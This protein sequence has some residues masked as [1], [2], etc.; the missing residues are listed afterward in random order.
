MEGSHFA[1]LAEP[2]LKLKS[3]LFP[4]TMLATIVAIGFLGSPSSGQVSEETEHFVKEARHLSQDNDLSLLNP[5]KSQEL[6]Q[7][8]TTSTGLAISPL[9]V[10]GCLGFYHWWVAAPEKRQHLN[11]FYQPYIWGTF[12]AISLLFLLNSCIGTIIP[13]LKKPMDF[14]ES[15]ENT[16]SAFLIGLPLILLTQIPPN[17]EFSVVADP[18]T[19]QFAGMTLPFFGSSSQAFTALTLLFW[20]PVLGVIS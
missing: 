8:I 12:L 16:F 18:A 1:L 20:A 3:F 6:S 5:E 13:F 10:A 2:I 15:I 19:H 4:E 9:M 17:L 7:K 14:V 11:L